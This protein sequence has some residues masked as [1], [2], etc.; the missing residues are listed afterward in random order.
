MSLGTAGS[1]LALDYGIDVAVVL[2]VAVLVSGPV[3]GSPV[4]E[5]GVDPE[6]ALGLEVVSEADLA[7]D[8]EVEPVLAIGPVLGVGPALAFVLALG[9]GPGFSLA[10]ALAVEIG[11]EDFPVPAAPVVDTALGLDFESDPGVDH[12]PGIARGL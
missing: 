1:S 2:V 9:N 6:A 5:A 4:L 8:P 3:D 11:S 7:F 12:V 10:L